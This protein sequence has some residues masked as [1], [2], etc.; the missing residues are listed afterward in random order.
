MEELNELEMSLFSDK[1]LELNFE[2]LPEIDEEEITD[3]I[4]ESEDDSEESDETEKTT[5]SENEGSEKVTEEEDESEGDEDDSPNLYSSFASVLVEQGLLPSVD[6]QSS[7]IESIDDL[8]TVFRSEIDNQV[9]GYLVNKLGEEGYEAIEKGVTLQEYQQYSNDVNTLD[10]I[11]EEVLSQ[12]LE[13]AKRI[14]L[15]DYMG[16]GIEEKRAIRLLK[17]TIDLGEDV[18]LEDARE[19]LESLKVLQEKKLVQLEQQREKQR[20][21]QLKLQEKID[22][23]LKNTIYNSDE[24]IKGV[25]VDKAVK[26]KVYKSITDIVGTAPN[27]VAENKLMRDRREN[28]IGFDTKLYYLYEI[29][30]GFKDFSSLV[31]RSQTTALSKLEKQLR[32]TKFEE[33]GKPSYMEDPES[34]G[35]F[36]SELV[37]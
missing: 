3:E 8:T 4:E 34:Y 26:D 2:D 1:A 10:S 25:K 17:K 35:G 28:P 6:L 7:K 29:T 32:K 14:I 19:S 15:E 11:T 9:K 20:A 31:N 21:D 23:D 37:L 24:Y 16:Q 5:L 18:I 12:D 30:N 22:N 36:G 13:L 33:S 27:G